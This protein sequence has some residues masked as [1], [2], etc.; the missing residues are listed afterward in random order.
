MKSPDAAMKCGEQKGVR[1]WGT[2]I[3]YGLPFGQ[4]FQNLLLWLDAN[5]IDILRLTFE[6]LCKLY[7]QERYDC[8]GQILVSSGIL[9]ANL[10]RQNIAPKYSSN[11]PQKPNTVPRVR[12]HTDKGGSKGIK[13]DGAINPSRGEPQGVHVET[14]PFGSPRTASAETGAYGRGRYVEFDA[15][16]NMIR[17][18][19][20]PRNTAVIPSEGPLPINN[21][22]PIYK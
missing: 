20:G 22:N 15:P 9:I 13:N 1:Q 14:E 5:G 17:T 3:R 12:H 2:K 6:D 11:A 16:E 7:V 18:N 21:S 10:P 4:Q 8:Y 19:V